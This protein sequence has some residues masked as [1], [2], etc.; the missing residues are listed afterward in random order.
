[1]M[2]S[3]ARIALPEAQHP[4][5]QTRRR[6]EIKCPPP[7]EMSANQSPDDIAQGAADWNCRAKNRHDATARFD[8]KEIGQ[9]RRRS[10]SVATFANSNTY[11]RG[12]EN[13]ECCR[14]TRAAA[15]QAPQNHSGADDEP[16][17]DSVG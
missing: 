10:R 2:R 4:Q 15:C 16:A 7:A 3:G 8:R 5:Q 17:R 1:M 14:Q 11:S 12:K 6:N 9:D 13:G